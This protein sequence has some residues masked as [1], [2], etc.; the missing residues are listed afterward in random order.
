MT[1]PFEGRTSILAR[2]RFRVKQETQELHSFTHL[3]FTPKT[4]L[5]ILASIL[6][7]SIFDHGEIMATKNAMVNDRREIFGWAMYDW[8]NS[9]FSTTIGTVFLA[10][11]RGMAGAGC[12]RIS[13][14]GNRF[15]F[16]DPFAPDLFLPYCISFS[17]GM[18]VLFLPILGAIA[19]YSHP[20]TDDANLC[21][22][23]RD[24]NHP[25]VLCHGDCGGSATYFSSSQTFPLARPWFFTTAYLPDI[26]SEDERD[27]V[28]LRTA[29]RWDIWAAVCCSH[30]TSFFTFSERIGVPGR[31]GVRINL[32]SAGNW[33]LGFAS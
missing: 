18:Q 13:G 28:W 30:S 16:W 7:K 22:H 11:Y 17:V 26:A 15:I 12:G 9:A 27:N 6:F 29:G 5:L 32:A 25:D 21:H 19:D 23:R 2:S 3:C 8:A 10:P 33:W 31:S 20:Q 24:P 1:C 14:H 4:K